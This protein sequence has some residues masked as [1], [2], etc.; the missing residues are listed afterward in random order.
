MAKG[1]CV[2]QEAKQSRQCGS[3][4]FLSKSFIARSRSS[5]N[6]RDATSPQF[7]NCLSSTTKSPRCHIPDLLLA[8][9]AFPSASSGAVDSNNEYQNQIQSVSYSEEFLLSH[10]LLL[11]HLHQPLVLLL[12]SV[13]LLVS[14]GIGARLQ[15]PLSVLVLP[16]IFDNGER[17]CGDLLQLAVHLSILLVDSVLSLCIFVSQWS[18]TQRRTLF[19][20]PFASLDSLQRPLHLPHQL[21]VIL[22]EKLRLN[23]GTA[24]IL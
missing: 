21:V 14:V 20:F 10:F 8:N 16:Q 15:L 2:S 9:A 24:H 12:Y 6:N 13:V 18:D 19:I 7:R 11:K 17:S 22:F 3:P 5:T 1:P 23:E 4:A